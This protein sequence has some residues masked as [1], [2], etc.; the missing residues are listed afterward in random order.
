FNQ[1]TCNFQ[2]FQ[3][4]VEVGGHSIDISCSVN[5]FFKLFSIWLIP[6]Q[7]SQALALPPCRLE[8]RIIGRTIPC[9]TLFCVFF[10]KKDCLVEF[11][12][13]KQKEST[14]TLLLARKLQLTR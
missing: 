13:K 6:F 11:T 3:L 9:A 10:L 5:H 12:S 7:T 4:S 8:L 2:A 14:K 1:V